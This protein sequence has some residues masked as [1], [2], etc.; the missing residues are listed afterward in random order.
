MD[1]VLAAHR[2]A[3]HLEPKGAAEDRREE[4]LDRADSGAAGEASAAAAQAIVAEAVIH[5]AL[6]GV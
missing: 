1:E 5:L 6:L 2:A 3:P 4:I